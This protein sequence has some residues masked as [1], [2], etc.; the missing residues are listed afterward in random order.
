MSKSAEGCSTAKDNVKDNW[1]L[2]HSVDK[3]SLYHSPPVH[4]VIFIS[5]SEKVAES[6][7]NIKQGRISIQD[8]AAPVRFRLFTH[9][10][11]YFYRPL[12]TYVTA[13]RFVS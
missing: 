4:V 13:G 2:Q 7:R 10:P 3:K 8:K 12:M 9:L 5:T 11:K 1:L 6:W